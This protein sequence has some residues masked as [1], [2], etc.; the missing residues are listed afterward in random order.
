M[1]L[2]Y[3]SQGLGNIPKLKLVTQYLPDR[4]GMVIMHLTG[5]A[6]DPVF[7]RDY[8]PWTGAGRP[9]A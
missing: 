6:S 7:G 5:P 1:R 4:A 9:A 8:G 2:T 3:G